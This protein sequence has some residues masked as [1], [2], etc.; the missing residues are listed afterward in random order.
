MSKHGWNSDY[1]E[2]VK[3]IGEESKA[4]AWMN[5]QTG[6]HRKKWDDIYVISSISFASLASLLA[7]IVALIPSDQVILTT[8][9]GVAVPTIAALA[10]IA[11]GIRK[12]YVWDQKYPLNYLMYK[13]FNALA[14][15]CSMILMMRRDHR[16]LTGK[17]FV[18]KKGKKYNKLVKSDENNILERFRKKFV[19]QYS[20]LGIYIPDQIKEILISKDKIP[21]LTD[22]EPV[23]DKKSNSF[24]KMIRELVDSKEDSSFLSV[25]INNAS[26]PSKAV[27]QVE[28]LAKGKC[29]S[30]VLN[31]EEVNNEIIV[32]NMMNNLCREK[33]DNVQTVIDIEDEYSDY[34]D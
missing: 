14:N 15:D 11:G 9:L 3:S 12:H 31:R 19:K 26:F 27:Q 34:S 13:K 18:E 5:R 25:P 8:V 21:E 23:D 6:N 22:S 29:K 16:Y 30:D 10:A 17:K 1:E 4:Y 7:A 24:T 2:I 28:N 33:I 20:N 32:S